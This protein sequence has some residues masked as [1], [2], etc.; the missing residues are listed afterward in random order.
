MA[1]N[2]LKVTSY[3]CTFSL[4]SPFCTLI[5]ALPVAKNGILI[6]IGISLS[7]SISRIMK[8]V[9]KINLSTLTRTY[10]IIPYGCLRDLFANCKVTAIGLASPKLSFLKMESDIK[11]VLAP[12]SQRTFSKIKFPIAHGIVKLHESLSL[13]GNFIC[14]IALHSSE[15]DTASYSPN[16]FFLARIFVISFT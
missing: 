13:G 12:K 5:N 3:S 4:N 14:K 6:I 8:S 11:L 9:G 7:F 1:L 15:S 2:T 16:F 10:S